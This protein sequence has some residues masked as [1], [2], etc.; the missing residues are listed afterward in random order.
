MSA[1]FYG[2][3]SPFLYFCRQIL[4]LD[5]KKL[6]YSLF[7]FFA[8]G[9]AFQSCN[10]NETYA[11]MKENEREA[12]EAYIK[13]EGIKVISLEQF[14]AQDSITD[15]LKNEY[16][17]FKDKGVYM[18]IVRKGEGKP[19]ADGERAELIARYY[20]VNIKE[21]DTLTGNIYDASNPDLL[22]I[23]NKSGNYSGSFT[24]GYMT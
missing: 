18:Q 4:E 24:S 21:G 6:I 15:T 8:I 3:L 1:K 12:I 13:S 17:L 2:V 20:E 7:A 14:H 9:M 10:D 19:I 23:E 22:T 16:V 5:M 11:D